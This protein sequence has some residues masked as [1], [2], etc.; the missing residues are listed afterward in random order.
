SCCRAPVRCS[1]LRTHRLLVKRRRPEI[2]A[3]RQLIWVSA[4]SMQ[5]SIGFRPPSSRSSTFPWN[6]LPAAMKMEAAGKSAD[7]IWRVTGLERAADERWTFEIPDKGYQVNPNV[8]KQT[9]SK[10]FTLKLA[11][12][13][14]HRHNPRAGGR[15]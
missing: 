7:E 11:V 8:G 4:P 5:P 6:K 1:Q 14:G 13:V 10:P 15:D 9:A 2:T 12:A 3:R